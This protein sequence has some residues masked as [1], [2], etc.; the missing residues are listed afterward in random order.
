MLIK[1]QPLERVVLTFSGDAQFSVHKNDTLVY[2]GTFKL[3]QAR[4]IYSGKDEIK[5]ETKRIVTNHQLNY[6]NII[7]TD[8]VVTTLSSTKLSIGDNTYDGFGSSFVKN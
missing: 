7:V 6:R 5:I 4:S 1:P 2:Y 3:S 8:G